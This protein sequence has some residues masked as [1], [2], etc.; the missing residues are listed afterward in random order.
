[1]PT[2]GREV[3]N[4]PTSK[5]SLHW[6]RFFCALALPLL[7]LTR[8]LGISDSASIPRPVRGR[9][10][11]TLTGAGTKRAVAELAVLLPLRL[12]VG[13]LA[14]EVFA[15]HLGGMGTQPRGH[16]LFLTEDAL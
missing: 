2:P 10:M 6:E 3:Q 15:H 11:K 5:R 12:H 4:S 8:R 13:F 9:V 1:M 16:C 7:S 14:G